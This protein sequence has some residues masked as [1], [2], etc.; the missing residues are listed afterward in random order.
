M[1]KAG[2]ALGLSVLMAGAAVAAPAQDPLKQFVG[3]TASMS[4]QPD[5]EGELDPL[6]SGA[7][8]GAIHPP[9]DLPADGFA[10]HRIDVLSGGPDP[11]GDT[12]VVVWRLDG[13][14]DRLKGDWRI[15]GAFRTKV[16]SE[17]NFSIEC[18]GNAK[19]KAPM[20]FVFHEGGAVGQPVK[21]VLAAF[22]LDRQG[23]KIERLTGKLPACKATE[24]PF[25]EE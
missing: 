23:G 5:A 17:S 3:K 25:S 14:T 11:S 18:A 1:R 21:R 12:T 10:L 2:L 13:P 8:F 24:E 9:R 15:I 19:D 22:R 7:G 16:S 20:V 4:I 6:L